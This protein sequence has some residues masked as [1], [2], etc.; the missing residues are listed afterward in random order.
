MQL[1]AAGSVGWKLG[2]QEC[3]VLP[4]VL[5]LSLDAINLLITS[6]FVNYLSA[7]LHLAGI[8]SLPDVMVMP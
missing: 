3:G 4:K 7:C 5:S 1:G 8:I 2:S 6:H